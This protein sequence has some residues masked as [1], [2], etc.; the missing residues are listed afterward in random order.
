VVGVLTRCEGAG[1]VF[2]V[3]FSSQCGACW[4]M[5]DYLT[6]H[7]LLAISLSLFF[8]FFARC[9]FVSCHAI[10]ASVYSIAIVIY[11]VS[12]SLLSREHR[13]RIILPKRVLLFFFLVY[14]FSLCLAHVPK[15]RIFSIFP[16]SF[17]ASE[18]Y[19]AS[20]TVFAI[21]SGRT[22]RDW[23]GESVSGWTCPMW[24]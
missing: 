10:K 5:G 22:S 23:L 7:A 8:F 21:A 2:F 13:F 3:S 1:V 9:A 24:R 20:V 18:L 4:P 19:S 12:L 16:C 6:A 14:Y 17:R 11:S 15:L